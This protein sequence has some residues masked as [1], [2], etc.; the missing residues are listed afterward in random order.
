[1]A[2]REFSTPAADYL[3]LLEGHFRVTNERTISG[4]MQE[5]DAVV[6]EH[7]E[8]G[9]CALESARE[10]LYRSVNAF[11]PALS[12]SVHVSATPTR[13]AAV[14]A[15]NPGEKLPGSVTTP[16]SGAG[17]APKDQ[18]GDLG[19]LMERRARSLGKRLSCTIVDVNVTAPGLYTSYG[20]SVLAALA[21]AVLVSKGNRMVRAA[22]AESRQLT[23]RE[24]VRTTSFLLAGFYLLADL[25]F[26]PL[27][28]LVS[29]RLR[30]PWA[31]LLRGRME[32]TPTPLVELRNAVAARKIEE[33]LAPKLQQELGRRPRIAIFYGGRHLTIESYLC[34]RR[35]RDG[36]LGAW[37]LLGYPGVIREH[38]N[39]VLDLSY[40]PTGADGGTWTLTEKRCA[41]FP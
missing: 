39:R 2:F 27:V 11:N 1:M 40:Q 18:L 25:L 28:A 33:Q 17:F 37:A 5:L 21:G 36:L 32:L 38:L 35:H 24:F 10:L 7:I 4:R 3:L 34:S 15:G 16:G 22:Q 8:L 41:A 30:D 13:P 6:L 14:T 12:P 31:S 23:R 19:D 29:G 26:S 20:I 9:D